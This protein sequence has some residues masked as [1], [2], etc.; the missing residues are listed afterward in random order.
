MPEDMIELKD[1]NVEKRAEFNT[2]MKEAMKAKDEIA[3]STIRL[4]IAA[5]KDRDIN[6]RG[7]GNSEGIS[8]SEILSMLQSMIKQREE[9]AKTYTD[10]AR[11]DLADREVAEIAIIRRFL[12]KQMDEAEVKTAIDRVLAEMNVT[13]IREMGKVMA[14]IKERYAGQM[15]M[16]KVS[17]MVK[18]RLA[19]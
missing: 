10:A 2:A 1:K 6:A 5:L 7:L 11:Q 3:L 4:I 12:P 8:E 19:G 16:G 13:D 15:D 14:T 18:Q 17:G 9:S